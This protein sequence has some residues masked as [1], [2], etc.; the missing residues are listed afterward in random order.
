MGSQQDVLR[1][2]KRRTSFVRIVEDPLRHWSSDLE[3]AGLSFALLARGY[4]LNHYR[5][6]FKAGGSKNLERHLCF[7]WL[8][9]HRFHRCT[10]ARVRCR[11]SIRLGL[12]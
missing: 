7:G 6:Q 11:N 4:G 12:L 10:T 9:H 3:V 2:Q 1:Y 5:R 8:Y